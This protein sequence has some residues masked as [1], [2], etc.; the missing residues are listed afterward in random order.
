MAPCTAILVTSNSAEELDNCRIREPFT[1]D[2][3]NLAAAELFSPTAGEQNKAASQKRDN[4]Q[5]IFALYS[6]VCAIDS[7]GCTWKQVGKCLAEPLKVAAF[8]GVISS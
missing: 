7:L 8:L 1:S 2:E 5:P 4:I 6:G 3:K